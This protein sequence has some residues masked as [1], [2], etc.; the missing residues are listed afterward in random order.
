VLFA[1][2]ALGLVSLVLSQEIGLEKHLQNDLFCVKSD[3][4]SLNSVNGLN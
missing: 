2:V 4:K 3:V 1:F